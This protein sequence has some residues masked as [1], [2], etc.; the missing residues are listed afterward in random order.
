LGLLR[1]ET[2]ATHTNEV[3]RSSTPK[4][5]NTRTM[6]SGRGFNSAYSKTTIASRYTVN[7]VGQLHDLFVATHHQHGQMRQ[8]RCTA[9]LHGIH[10]MALEPYRGHCICCS[11]R[12]PGVVRA[13]PHIHL[14][15]NIPFVC[16]P[17][18]LH[19]S[20]HGGLRIA[21]CVPM[22]VEIGMLSGM[23]VVQREA[24]LVA[25]RS[26]RRSRRGFSTT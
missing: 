23:V 11:Q 17:L 21:E 22:T 6:L 25:V 19:L 12:T 9:G 5:G 7:L 18:T 13:C 4:Y 14:L 1:F 26:A 3:T 15:G 16:Y 2:N 24:G 10:T 20:S 8:P